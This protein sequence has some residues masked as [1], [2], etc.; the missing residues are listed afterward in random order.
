[1]KPHDSTTILQ[2]LP[3]LSSP[4]FRAWTLK[5]AIAPPTFAFRQSARKK[6]ESQLAAKLDKPA[7]VGVVKRLEAE[8]AEHLAWSAQEQSAL[9]PRERR[10]RLRALTAASAAFRALLENLD[11]DTRREVAARIEGL[12]ESS[13]QPFSDWKP[14]EMTGFDRRLCDVF[15]KLLAFEA[16]VV[17][18]LA[19]APAPS[20][21]RP[22]RPTT[23]KFGVDVAMALRRTAPGAVPITATRDGPFETI[24]GICLEATRKEPISDVHRIALSVIKEI[25]RRPT[26]CVN[27]TASA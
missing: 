8:V 24:L 10:R 2:A 20:A 23:L 17:R 9:T 18:H 1:M 11:W 25:Q 21:G 22:P 26:G 4:L 6:I 27:P 3:E 12:P 19:A 14:D 7:I 16:D 13:E 15:G 5:E